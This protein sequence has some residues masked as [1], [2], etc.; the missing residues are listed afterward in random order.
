MAES[1]ECER[2]SCSSPRRTPR[3]AG[4]LDPRL[5]MLAQPDSARASA[6]R[7]LRDDLLDRGLPRVVAVSSA[8]AETRARRRA[9]SISPWPSRSVAAR[10]SSSWTPTSSSPELA[11]VFGVDEQHADLVVSGAPVARPLHT[12]RAHAVS[13]RS[14]DGPRPHDRNAV[15]HAEVRHADRSALRCRL[16]SDRHRRACARRLACGPERHRGGRWRAPHG[17][18]WSHDDAALLRALDQ[19]GEGELLGATLMESE[20]A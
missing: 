10:G 7:Q 4:A 9:R 11:E 8:G 20:R 17:A 14:H 12:R 19:V 1:G 3:P 18:V 2:L 13:S 6:F 5:V 15:R 16:R